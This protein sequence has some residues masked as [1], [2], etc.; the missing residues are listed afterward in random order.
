MSAC[1][2]GTDA[3]KLQ[4]GNCR[5]KKVYKQRIMKNWRGVRTVLEA[6]S[7]KC[8]SAVWANTCQEWHKNSSF[9]LRVKEWLDVIELFSILVFCNS[10]TVFIF[11]Y[12]CI[13]LTEIALHFIFNISVLRTQ[14]H[15]SISSKPTKGLSHPKCA[16]CIMGL[17][18]PFFPDRL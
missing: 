5:H 10:R 8:L 17:R 12:V 18:Y 3:P 1:R 14:W 13:P 7:E 9:S 4:Q 16:W 6:P 15:V 2:T 11:N